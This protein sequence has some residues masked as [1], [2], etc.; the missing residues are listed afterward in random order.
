MARAGRLERRPAAA[1]VVTIAFFAW[2]YLPI[3]AVVL[4][5]FNDEKSLSAFTGFSTRWYVD[6]FHN[7]ALLE[8]LRAS[9]FIAL[10]SALGSLVLGTMLA[11]GLERVRSRRGR[12]VG[13]ITLLPLVTP[14][15]VTGVA[16]LLVFTGAGLRLGLDT[17]ILAEITFSI[18]YVT[19]I[20]RGRLASIPLEVEEAARD[21]GCTP[22]QSLRLV[23]LPALV[24]ALLASGLLVF[25]LV[26]DDFVLAFFTTGV[27]PQ[28]L[29]VRI[30]SSIRFGVSPAINAVGTLMLAVSAVLIVAALML[31]RLFNRKASSLD[32]ITGG[33]R[34]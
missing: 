4:F 30:Y 2:L 34:R 18:A 23:T 20:V 25:A 21:L 19:V 3:L 10:V 8:S 17:V 28:P 15:I 12:V 33:E 5:S 27:D 7:E 26:F 6:F 1:V 16:A 22:W 13:A 24:P 29:P 9:L 14:E 32:L 11:L 31:P